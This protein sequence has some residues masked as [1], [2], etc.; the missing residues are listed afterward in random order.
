M[1]TLQYHF[2][3]LNQDNRSRPGRGMFSCYV[4]VIGMLFYP[5]LFCLRVFG[6]F[7][8]VTRF[9]YRR[10]QIVNKKNISFIN[11]LV[12]FSLIALGTSRSCK[13]RY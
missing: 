7:E 5:F 9:P 4:P 13:S 10:Q 6:D 11:L 2:I 12:S 3:K 8:R 1:I